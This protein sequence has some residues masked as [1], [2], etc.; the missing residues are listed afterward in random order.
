M[1]KDIHYYM[2]FALALKAGIEFETARDIA[3]SNQYTDELKEAD[4]HGIKTQCGRVD[5]WH[6][7]TVQSDVLVPFHFLPGDFQNSPWVVTPG[8]KIAKK[9]CSQAICDDKD[10]IALGIALHSLQDTY[11]HQGWTGWQ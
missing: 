10:P 11:S 8:C 9:L 4:L 6:V 1:Q 3:W 2:T 7:R 5:D